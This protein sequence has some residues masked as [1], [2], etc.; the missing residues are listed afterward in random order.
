MKTS[1]VIKELSNIDK[2]E[3]VICVWFKKEDF[4]LGINDDYEYE[5]LPNAQWNEIVSRFES[6]KW[7]NPT[8]SSWTEVH[9][10]IY[11]LVGEK[12]NASV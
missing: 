2:D 12:V 6:T 10:D 9:K 11:Q 3:E 7:D 5:T 4:P 8:S 1:D